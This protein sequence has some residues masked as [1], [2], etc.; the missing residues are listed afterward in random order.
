MDADCAYGPCIY[1]GLSGV[2][3]R[4]CEDG[5]CPDPSWT[6]IENNA[7]LAEEA[8]ENRDFPVGEG[9]V[10]GG[11]AEGGGGQGAV[12]GVGAG[13]G[14]YGAIKVDTELGVS[15]EVSISLG[16]PGQGGEGSQPLAHEVFGGQMEP[17]HS[18]Y[19]FA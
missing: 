11:G 12:G 17:Y 9:G 5:V 18:S 1:N 15:D 13:G 6:C 7:E 4:Y 16:E 8:E 14:T 19:W 3:T 10:G 2:C